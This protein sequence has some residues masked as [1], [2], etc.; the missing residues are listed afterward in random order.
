MVSA[1]EENIGTE[2][3][4]IEQAIANLESPDLGLRFYAAWWLGRFKI[5]EQAA[6][7]KLIQALKDEDDRTPEGGYPLRRNAARAL[8]KI[9]N[10]EAIPALIESLDSTD[11]YVREAAAQSLEMLGDPCCIPNLVKLLQKGLS[12]EDL[13]SDRK[14][15]V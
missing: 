4:T 6:V 10:S 12:G 9:G 13:V 15:V 3:L 1:K 14:S 7:T 2:S 8:G 5:Q 11:F